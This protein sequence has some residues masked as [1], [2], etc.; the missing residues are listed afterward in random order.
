MHL[1]VACRRQRDR[2]GTVGGQL[3][4]EGT[5]TLQERGLQAQEGGAPQGAAVRSGALLTPLTHSSHM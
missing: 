2:E 4:W 5:R 1:V 3:H